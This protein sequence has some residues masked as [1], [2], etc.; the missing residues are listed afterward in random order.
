MQ[1]QS[2]DK[3]TAETGDWSSRSIGSNWQHQAF[4]LMIRLGGRRAAY[5]LLYVVVAYY[6]LFSRLARQRASHYLRRRFPETTGWLQ[7][8]HCYQLILSF[9]KVLVDRAVVGIMGPEALNVTLDAR[10]ELLKLRDEQRGMIMM[11]AHVGCWQVAMSALD[12]LQR[13]VNML[14][15]RED[16]DI[17]RHYYEHAG[18]DCPY[19]VIDPTGY[20]G[21]TLEMLGAL[22][23]GQ[24]VCVMGDRLLGSDRSTVEVDLL[25]EKVSLPFSA[26]KIASATGAPVVVFLTRK[27]GPA[28]YRL[29][30]AQVIRVPELQGRNAE[31]FRPYAAE[32]SAALD[33][34]C[35][36]YPYQFFNFFD[37]WLKQQPDNK[38]TIRSHDGYQ[39]KTEAGS[40]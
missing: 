9:G 10:E 12:F 3:Q 31:T 35:Q 6:V 28:S 17:D 34:F 15:R 23:Q 21:G 11:S 38:P 5:L 18:I 30:L 36:E 40:D 37:M 13:P 2:E 7:L 29:Q 25:G 4:Y 14:M 32:F 20:L 27:D 26:Y 22:K 16:G 39:G 8:W 19:R 24:I 33:K 1:K